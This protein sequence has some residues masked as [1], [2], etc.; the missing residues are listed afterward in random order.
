MTPFFLECMEVHSMTYDSC[1]SR[2]V[3]GAGRAVVGP[4]FYP[5]T[6]QHSLSDRVSRYQIGATT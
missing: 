4:N 1:R 5:N 3:G 2:S 6:L